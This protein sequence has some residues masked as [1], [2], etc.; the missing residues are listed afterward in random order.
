MA[1][2]P[3]SFSPPRAR[4]YASSISSTPPSARSKAA[5]TRPG[6]LPDEPG[7]QARPVGLDQVAPLDDAQR[8]VDLGQQSGDGGLARARVAGEHEV[9]ALVEHGQ[10]AL[11]AD[12]L[13]AEQVR[14]EV[15]LVLDAVEADEGVELGQQLVERAGRGQLLGRGRRG[16]GRGLGLGRGAAVGRSRSG[17]PGGA[18]GGGDRRLHRGAERLDGGQLGAGRQQVQGGDRVP[19]V[20]APALEA[21]RTDAAVAGV[22]RGQDLEQRRR[23]AQEHPAA[24]HQPG[25][26]DVRGRGPPE[27][28]RHAVPER[29][30]EGPQLVVGVQAVGVDE[31]TR[32]VVRLDLDVG[33]QARRCRGRP[34]S[35]RAPRPRG[36]GRRRRRAPRRRARRSPPPSVLPWAPVTA[37]RATSATSW[38]RRAC[39]S[40]RRPGSRTAR[41]TGRCRASTTRGRRPCPRRRSG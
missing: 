37:G 10:V 2:R 12:L 29:G 4:L 21:L 31:R 19:D 3:K 16:L 40:A 1:S 14:D 38:D 17:L 26:A 5:T 15:D 33:P 27:V 32:Q 36:P 23:P 11:A 34:R 6:G 30:G 41:S 7:D 24:D 39:R 18:A 8:A 13:D 20:C 22:G 25:L 9:P 28:G 35:S